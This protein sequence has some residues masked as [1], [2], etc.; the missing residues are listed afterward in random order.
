MAVNFSESLYLPCM[1][2]FARPII[3][4]PIASQPGGTAYSGRGYW[5]TTPVDVLMEDGSV[6]SDA[7]Q[8]ALDIRMAEFPVVPMQR[9]RIDVPF[10]QGVAGGSFEV[11]DLEGVGNAGGMMTLR[12]KRVV[13]SKP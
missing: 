12:L 2:E 4:T 6:F 1:N 3:V 5:D 11:S 9:D 13:E 10:H 7:S 8:P